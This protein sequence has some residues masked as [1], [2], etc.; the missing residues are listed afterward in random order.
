M[1]NRHAERILTVV[2]LTLLSAAL[3]GLILLDNNPS[4]GETPP[5]REPRLNSEQPRRYILIYARKDPE[6]S[7][8]EARINQY[9]ASGYSLHS[10]LPMSHNYGYIAVMEK[11]PYTPK[12]CEH[13]LP[14]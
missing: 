7:G 6:S 14:E 2:V 12:C 4:G 11:T 8:L 3:L 10:L 13:L 5:A 9:A 1:K